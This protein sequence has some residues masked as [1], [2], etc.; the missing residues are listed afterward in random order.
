M[1]PELLHH[2]QEIRASAENLLELAGRPYFSLS[3][4]ADLI[5]DH[6]HNLHRHSKNLNLQNTYHPVLDLKHYLETTTITYQEKSYQN[7]CIPLDKA[8]AALSRS[9][10]HRIPSPLLKAV[11]DHVREEIKPCFPLHTKLKEV[12]QHQ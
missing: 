9:A 12:S 5:L 11:I 1:K 6:L 2:I 4:D 7:I 10:D 3:D 8:I